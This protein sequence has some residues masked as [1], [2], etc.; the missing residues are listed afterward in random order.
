[1]SRAPVGLEVEAKFDAPDE[2]L[3]QY[4]RERRQFGK[5]KVLP[6]GAAHLRSVYLDT[7]DWSLLDNGIA[8]RLRRSDTRAG[9]ELTVKW[10]GQVEGFLHE[11]LEETL[12][13]K[14]QP[15]LPLR[16][17]PKE[18][19]PHLAAVV[20]GRRLR[21]VLVTE[22]ERCCFGLYSSYGDKRRELV[23]LALD[24]VTVRRPDGKT[25]QR[26]REV[27]LELRG[28]K[29]EHL[30]EVARLLQRQFALRAN[31][32]SK[33]E[34]GLRAVYTGVPRFDGGRDRRG[35]AALAA[36]SLA[37]L[38]A[39]DKELRLRP[40][41]EALARFRRCLKETMVVLMRKG[42]LSAKAFSLL[43]SLAQL[44]VLLDS[45][46]R[47]RSGRL[48]C[49]SKAT[50]SKPK[51]LLESVLNSREYYSLLQTLE[52]AARKN[53]ISLPKKVA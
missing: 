14:K 22:V 1:M 25:V 27:E 12:L 38:R 39:R 37:C 34:R 31:A 5:Y 36:Q 11:R 15:R 45:Q 17:L 4:F 10:S 18:V 29:T 24:R 26:Y 13:L 43:E 28:G 30:R 32:A 47:R 41:S 21:P 53:G 50:Q 6:K 48:M 3:W 20:A 16:S 2:R 40:D 33:F 19:A 46:Q 9:C 42:R 7:L 8:L 49:W 35:S 51:R 44:Q 23:E 52:G